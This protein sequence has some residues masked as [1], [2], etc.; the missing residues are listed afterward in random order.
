MLK[1]KFKKKKFKKK[2]NKKIKKYN[3]IIRNGRRFIT[4]SNKK[5]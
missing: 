3:N 4:R 5:Q 1:K 2:E